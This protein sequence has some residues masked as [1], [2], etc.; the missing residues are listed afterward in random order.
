MRTS[1]S[2]PSAAADGAAGLAD[3]EGRSKQPARE[4]PA[5]C[6]Q[7]P[8]S[9]SL[10][11]SARAAMW[12]RSCHCGRSVR[13]QAQF[14]GLQPAP[15]RSLA[16]AIG[17]LPQRIAPRH[18]AAP[19]ARQ[20]VPAVGCQQ[21]GRTVSRPQLQGMPLYTCFIVRIGDLQDRGFTGAGAGAGV[22]TGQM[23]APGRPRRRGRSRA[24][25]PGARSELELPPLQAS[26]RS[27]GRQRSQPGTSGG[28]FRCSGG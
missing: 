28:C 3:F 19:A 25:E 23:A 14:P 12:S 4:R 1:T 10:H 27:A 6:A 17:T 13:H 26:A 24:A 5:R 18:R 7:V 21:P 15:D 2:R 11:C 16:S 20:H 8:G 22:G 9:S